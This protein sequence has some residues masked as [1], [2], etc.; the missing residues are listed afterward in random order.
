MAKGNVPP[1]LRGKGGGKIAQGSNQKAGFSSQK[2]GKVKV[3]DKPYKTGV[4]IKKGDKN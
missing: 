3:G 1:A 4:P 2:L